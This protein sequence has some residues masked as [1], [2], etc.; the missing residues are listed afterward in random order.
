[1]RLLQEQTA[2]LRATAAAEKAS[3]RAAHE[4]EA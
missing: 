4:R 2:E 1:V 3:I